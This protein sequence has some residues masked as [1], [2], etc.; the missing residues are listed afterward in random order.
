MVL[1]WLRSQP[2][3]QLSLSCVNLVHVQV[4]TKEALAPAV[5]GFVLC[6]QPPLTFH[7]CLPHAISLTLFGSAG[8]ADATIITVPVGGSQ[9][10]YQF[11]LSSRIY[12]S[13][14]MMVCHVSTHVS[15]HAQWPENHV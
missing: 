6:F 11:D 1:H 3:Q 10:L 8:G 7:N 13:V 12:M 15:V 9:A 2:R 4:S 5:P 14:T